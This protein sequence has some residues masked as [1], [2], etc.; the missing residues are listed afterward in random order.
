MKIGVKEV[1]L[2]WLR[3]TS[4]VETFHVVTWNEGLWVNIFLLVVDDVSWMLVVGD[5]LTL[6]GSD[7]V[8]LVPF[9]CSGL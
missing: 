8:C 2:I 7:D 6:G 4:L 3:A 1:V 9:I 5:E